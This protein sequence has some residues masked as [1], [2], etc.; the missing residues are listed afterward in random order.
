MNTC[1]ACPSMVQFR[2]FAHQRQPEAGTSWP[3]PLDTGY[4]IKLF[5]NAS[6]FV[7]QNSRAFVAH[8][9]CESVSIHARRDKDL[10]SLRTEL[11]RVR[12]QVR[13]RPGNEVRVDFHVWRVIDEAAQNA[14]TAAGRKGVQ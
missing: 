12:H 3:V 6:K 5:K 10:T 2:D 7:R 9:D 8:L 4:A 11:D 1:S 13:Q 14:D